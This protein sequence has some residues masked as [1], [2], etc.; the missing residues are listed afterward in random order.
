M[1]FV[2]RKEERF[3]ESFVNGQLLRTS[4]C[5]LKFTH[6]W[7]NHFHFYWYQR[8]IVIRS[9]LSTDMELTVLNLSIG[10]MLHYS[11]E[12]LTRQNVA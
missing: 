6:N 10:R 12:S 9:H 8:S 1:R 5:S 4:A 2:Q 3:D 7:Q 11:K